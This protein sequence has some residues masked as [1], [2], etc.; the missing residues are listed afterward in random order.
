P[1]TAEQQKEKRDT[2]NNKQEKIDAAVQKWMEDTN[3]LANRLAEEFD[4]KPRYFL[5]IFFQGGAHMINHQEAINPYNAFK[6]KKAAEVRE[7]GL[8]KDGTQL[9]ADYFAKY[10]QLTDDEKSQ[11]VKDFATKQTRNFNLRHDSPRA[12]VQDVANTV[13]NMKMLMFRI[14]QRVSIE[15][16]FCI[17]RNNVE[18]KMGPEWFFTSKDLEQY[19][20]IVMHKRWITGEVG[21]KL[22]A[23]AI[24]GCDPVS[25]CTVFSCKMIT[26]LLICRHVALRYA[27]GHLDEGRDLRDIGKEPRYVCNIF[28]VQCN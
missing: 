14:G 1:L 16:F 4:M 7:Q 6:N 10:Q 2:R 21:M 13:R 27:E 9:H 24:A 18:F 11:L 8:S 3:E 28:H 26:N 19:M 25:T 15:G 17:V 5:D 20:E 22:E 12:K 23:F